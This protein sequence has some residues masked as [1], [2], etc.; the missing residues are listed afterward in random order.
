MGEGE[1]ERERERERE[2]DR[3]RE[4]ERE[5]ERRKTVKERS[6]LRVG[7][8]ESHIYMSVPLSGGSKKNVIVSPSSV[9]EMAV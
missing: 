5:R 3:E 8:K 6:N 2:R 7:M 9:C 1:G 4:R